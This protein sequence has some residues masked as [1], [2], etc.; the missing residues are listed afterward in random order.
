MKDKFAAVHQVLDQAFALYGDRLIIAKGALHAAI[1][2]PVESDGTAWETMKIYSPNTAGQF[3]WSVTRDPNYK[4]NGKVPY[5]KSEI[6]AVFRQAAEMGQKY[7][8]RW[9]EPWRIDLL[10]PDLQEEIAYA[11][12]L[13]SQD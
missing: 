13:L 5:G 11:A 9:I 3:V 2:E 4:M 7:G 8:M 1:P 6:Q 10:N 12:S